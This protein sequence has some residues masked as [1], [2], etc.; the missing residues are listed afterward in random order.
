MAC[1]CLKCEGSMDG[2]K[3]GCHTRYLC[4]ISEGLIQWRAGAGSHWLMRGQHYNFRN[5]ESWL[6]IIKT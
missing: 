1:T 3:A 6:L 5:F 4:N 2:W